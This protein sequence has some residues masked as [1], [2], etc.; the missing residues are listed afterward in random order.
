VEQVARARQAYAHRRESLLAALN[1]RG[2]TAS[3]ADG[4][5]LWLAVDDQQ[6]AMLTLAAH[7]IA[8]APGAPFQV[9]PLGG[10]HVRLTVGLV[11]DGFD[12]LAEILC[13]AAGPG[14]RGSGGRA[15]AH[16]RGWR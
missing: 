10:D 12:E 9:G 8:V 4:I 2:L 15:R 6:V 1:A 13:E 3:A 16:P 7:G 11:R 5:N 14:H